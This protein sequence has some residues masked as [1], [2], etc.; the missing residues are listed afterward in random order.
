MSI[1]AFGSELVSLYHRG[2]H[3]VG[4]LEQ[5]SLIPF[6][7]AVI[8]HAAKLG[9]RARA[10]HNIVGAA[11]PADRLRFRDALGAFLAG[12]GIGACVPARGGQLARLIL[13]RTRLATSTFPGLVST[14]FAESAFDTVL[15]ALMVIAVAVAGTGPSGG[16]STLRTAGE[17]PVIA[18]VLVFA[19]ALGTCWVGLRCRV[20]LRSLLGDARC[21]LAVFARPTRY[22]QEV[23]SWQGLSWVLRVASTYLFLVAFHIPASLQAAFLVIAVQSVAG[24]VSVTPGGAGPQ[25]AMLV[26]AL[27]PTAATTVLGFGIGVQITTVFAD[28]A[29]GAA[30]LIFMTGSLR[31]RR[32]ALGRD[33][34]QIR[35]LGQNSDVA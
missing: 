33:A 3:L 9:V 16:A 4:S 12:S 29:L 32:L 27:S 20:R 25:Q 31:W 5:V 11:Y 24:L 8:L 2:L 22:L 6:A 34:A 30:S 15:A 18:A 17:D 26:V 19:M 14:L 21:G 1:G 23:A 10:W 7:V 13:V 28:V 35:L